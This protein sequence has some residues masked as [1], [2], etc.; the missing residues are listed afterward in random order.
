M[1]TSGGPRSIRTPKVSPKSLRVAAAQFPVTRDIRRNA[2]YIIR[3]I[4][5]AAQ[6]G[7]GVVQFP[8]TALSGY[9]PK[10]WPDLA[11]YPWSELQYQTDRICEVAAQHKI[12]VVLGTMTQHQTCLPA[13]S[14]L[15]ISD[16]GERVTSYAK[17]RLYGPEKRMFSA[18]NDTC[19]VDIQGYPCGLLICYDNCFPE[20]YEPYR[21]AGVQL[22]FHSFFNAENSQ[23]T[24]IQALMMANLRVRAADN[25]MCIAA[26]NSS[27]RYSPLAA[28]IVRPDGSAVSTRRHVASLVFD[29]F[30]NANLGW[31][32]DNLN[33]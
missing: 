22:L 16:C 17:Q 26:A 4:G 11:D 3:Q 20:L 12:W 29:D 23:A 2:R 31:T 13:S 28:C 8:E 30:P 7:A 9:P 5:R 25:R 27:A 21:R 33:P 18:G 32:Y 19:I 6:G 10:H 24:G 15:V 1:S 14:L